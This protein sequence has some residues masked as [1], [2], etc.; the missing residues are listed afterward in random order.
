MNAPLRKSRPYLFH[1]QTQSLC[2]TCLKLVPAKILIDGDDVW[3]QKRCREHGVQMTK[4]S[5]DA[6][7]YKA[8]LSFLKPGDRPLEV[9]TK[10]DFGCP[11]DCGLCP[12]HEQH[13]CL[14]IIEINEACNLTCPV[15]FAGSSQAATKQLDLPT[16]GRM[17]DALVAS[18]GEPDL[19][20]LSGGEP[21]IHP[22]I[23]QIIDMARE[24]PIRHLM[25]NTNG[26]RI[27]SD[28]AFAD[29]LA[30]RRAGLEVYLQFDSLRPE[31]LKALRGA[32]LSKV[33][34]NA[35]E[36]LEA[37]GISTT[38]VCTVKKGVNDDEMADII[39][40]ALQY[41]CVRGVTFQP[42][43]DAGRNL[44]FDPKTDRVL[45]TDIRRRIVEDSGIF[46]ESDMIPLPC[47]PTAISIGYGLR[48]GEQVV[49]VTAMIPKDELVAELPN[50]VTFERYPQLRERI[51]DLFSLSTIEPNASQRLGD[52]LCCLP[53]VTRAGRARLPER[54]PRRRV[55]FH[56]PVR[57]LRRQRQALLRPFRHAG[58][59][60][61]PVRDLQ[62]VLQKR[63]D[64][65]FP[66][67]RLSRVETVIKRSGKFHAA[68]KRLP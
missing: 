63:R 30:E 19:L 9:Q 50:A 41:R 32:D 18:E 39:A 51:F 54:L 28:P 26:L 37:R 60:D 3:Y 14:A 11:Y 35:L 61:H 25:I 20:Q 45:L 8:E 27:A 2:E 6:A 58:R 67:N 53:Q 56:G 5:S 23:V 31:A 24:R 64:R 40:H 21:T 7:Y 68:E 34:R 4:I 13:S 22:D 46:G 65:A 15:C 59:A 33:R 43:Q 17:M 62:P 1:G 42:I 44:D 55:E 36:A 52:L 47:N 12:D 66:R 49:P 16:I 57:F 10:T 38:L 48:N 29:A